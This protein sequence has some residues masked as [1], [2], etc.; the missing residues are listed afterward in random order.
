MNILS[1]LKTGPKIYSLI[2]FFILALGVISYTGIN[3]M[4]AIGDE[5][6][7]IAHKDIPL[8]EILAGVTSL[9]LEQTVILER[10][11]RFAQINFSQ[12][13]INQGIAASKIDFKK[14]QIEAD[15][16]IAGGEKLLVKIL[17]SPLSEEERTEMLKVQKALKQVDQ[18]HQGFEHHAE[19]LFEAID[20]HEGA[21]VKQLVEKLTAEEENLQEEV[22]SLLTEVERFTQKS[23]LHAEHTEEAAAKIMLVIGTLAG[24]IGLTF[25]IV[26][27]KLILTPLGGEPDEMQLIAEQVALGNLDIVRKK[28]AVG[29]YASLLSMTDRLNQLMGSLQSNADVLATATNEL[30]ATAM[31]IQKATEEVNIGLESSTSAIAESSANTTELAESIERMS[32]RSE[33][34]FRLAEEARSGAVTGQDSMSNTRT[35]IANISDSS[36]QISNIINVITEIAN[37]TNL[38]SLNAAIEAAKAGESGKGFAVVAEEVRLL[39]DRSGSA[40]DQ[41]RGL[42]EVSSSHVETGNQVV[43]KTS[44]ALENIA[45]HVVNIGDWVNQMRDDMTAQ[46]QGAKEMSVAIA[47]ISEISET[48]SAAM[49]ELASAMN[50]VD[51]TITELANMAESLKVDIAYFKVKEAPVGVA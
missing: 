43:V 35:A 13:E 41:I 36:S 2:G 38:L 27:T 29:L 16:K 31:Q 19:Q 9:Q 37:Q 10:S 50:Q 25:G 8:T 24:L 22:E 33:E 47:E 23:A 34:V 28:G 11:L 7:S 20:H 51:A 32:E 3:R 6:K 40:V 21:K 44:D 39:A 30:S 45:S 18:E 42:I 4:G 49:T 12:E 26:I 48:N 17:A 5:L 46:S 15:N 1:S 14:H